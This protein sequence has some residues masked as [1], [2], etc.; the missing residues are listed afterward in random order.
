[1]QIRIEERLLLDELAEDEG[2]QLLMIGRLVEVL[3]ETLVETGKRQSV[4]CLE[5]PQ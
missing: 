2:Q 4:R 5:L 1:M 3:A